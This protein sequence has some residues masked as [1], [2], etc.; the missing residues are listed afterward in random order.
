MSQTVKVIDVTKSFI[1]G[2]PSAFPENLMYTMAEDNP[3]KEPPI[4]AYEGYNFLPTAYGYRSYFGTNQKMTTDNP[5]TTITTDTILMYQDGTYQNV[6]I[7]LASDGIWTRRSSGTDWVN[8]VPL[9]DYYAEDGAFKQWTWCVIENT[10]YF[11][12][13][14]EETVNTIAFLDGTLDTI[15]PS[16][17]NMTGQIGIFRANGRLGFWDSA[18]SISWSSPY[19]TSKFTPDTKTLAGNT[20]F[21][22]I[23]GRIVLV[24]ASG[25]GFIIYATRSITRVNYTTTGSLIWD[26]TSITQEAGISI[27][28]NVTT[29]DSDKT[30]YAYTNIGLFSIGSYNVVT[31]TSDVKQIL[32][33]EMDFLREDRDPVYLDTID[34]RYLYLSLTKGDYIDGITEFGI[35]NTPDLVIDDIMT[36]EDYLAT[37]GDTPT[38]GELFTAIYLA[39][40]YP[41]GATIAAPTQGSNIVPRYI[42]ASPNF[43]TTF[44]AKAQGYYDNYY[45]IDD[46]ETAVFAPT[47]FTTVRLQDVID[48]FTNTYTSEQQY[49]YINS[50]ACFNT[51]AIFAQL[52]GTLI[53]ASAVDVP[54]TMAIGVGPDD[55]HLEYNDTILK[56]LYSFLSNIAQIDGMLR[57]QK[58]ALDAFLLANNYRFTIP[59][60]RTSWEA[61]AP[62]LPVTYETDSLLLPSSIVDVPHLASGDVVIQ[63]A[64]TKSK[65]YSRTIDFEEGTSE[66]LAVES[67]TQ[68]INVSAAS[69]VLTTSNGT[70]TYSGHSITFGTANF[71]HVPTVQ[72]IIDYYTTNP[73]VEA[74]AGNTWT[75]DPD[76]PPATYWNSAASYGTSTVRGIGMFFVRSGGGVWLSLQIVLQRH[77]I[78]A[79]VPSIAVART[80]CYYNQPANIFD[81]TSLAGNPNFEYLSAPPT[82]T[83]FF[84]PTMDMA[85]EAYRQYGR[86]LVGSGAFDNSPVSGKAFY[87]TPSTVSIEEVTDYIYITAEVIW[88]GISQGIKRI[89]R[90]LRPTGL[91][92]VTGNLV[93]TYEEAAEET[94]SAVADSYHKYIAYTLES[95]D[96]ITRDGNVDTLDSQ[97][98]SVDT[99]SVT[100]WT[101]ALAVLTSIGFD[102][103]ETN[104]SGVLT[105]QSQN[106]QSWHFDNDTKLSGPFTDC[107]VG[108][109]AGVPQE[110]GVVPYTDL[111]ILCSGITSSDISWLY[112]DPFT[113]AGTSFILQDGVPAPLYPTLKGA[114]VYDF[115]LKKWGKLKAEYKCILEMSPINATHSVP[116]SVTNFGMDAGILDLNGDIRLF[117]STPEDSW[118]KYGKIG[119][120]RKGWTNAHEVRVDNRIPM[121]G[122]ITLEGST[123][124]RL[125]DTTL[126]YTETVTGEKTYTMYPSISANWYNIKVSG[127]YDLTFMEFRGT[128]AGRR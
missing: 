68:Y 97:D 22:A 52:G 7:A 95:L 2:D 104:Q 19:D 29:A 3:E 118:I 38:T 84:Y 16:F 26:A 37:L 121:T 112:T 41:E 101:T 56:S 67:T 31:R 20:I 48:A 43:Q 87:W 75:P 92:T 61:I 117:D 126:T 51:S 23:L 1:P 122:T 39:L 4:L 82:S 100:D 103:N 96:T 99:S 77:L 21:N 113:Y 102:N 35:G 66:E 30:H 53:E 114:W 8:E 11:Y 32:T 27:A 63:A 109:M 73:G 49:N 12:R 127:K 55:I 17:L 45:V 106:C 108:E 94:I 81:Y 120:Y 46:N 74:V 123:D 71:D 91:Y 79:Y 86:Y 88:G 25:E 76:G 62:I 119:Y 47:N 93:L 60:S 115:I 6:L 65:T 10:G 28:R 13:E 78:D 42:V 18:N 110:L 58:A 44:Y 24:K 33:Q 15:S 111:P 59:L 14:G 36:V 80:C 5:L 69:N 50:P 72:E 57:R 40:R 64:W 98:V 70:P 128:I 83:S 34:S 9:D 107:T 105:T 85:K 125:P 116:L 90:L 89:A 124:G 54:P